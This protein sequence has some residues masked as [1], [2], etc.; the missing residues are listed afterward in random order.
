MPATTIISGVAE[1]SPTGGAAYSLETLIFAS[2]SS[3]LSD[4][5]LER[6][7]LDG[8]VI[9]ASDQVDGRAI[10]SMVTSGPAGA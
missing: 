10:S 2:A 4:A 8:I 7:D 6:G 5:G 9:A 1:V 3:A